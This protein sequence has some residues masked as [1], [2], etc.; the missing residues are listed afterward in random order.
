MRD[1]GMAVA[2]GYGPGLGFGLGAWPGDHGLVGSAALGLHSPTPRYEGDIERQVMDY[3]RAGA[4]W[5]LYQCHLDHKLARI[6]A[7]LGPQGPPRASRVTAEAPL[8]YGL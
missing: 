1:R 6:T 8:A 3:A 7:M 5:P 4:G 2:R